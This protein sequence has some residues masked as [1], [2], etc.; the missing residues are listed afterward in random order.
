MSELPLVEGWTGPIEQTLESNGTPVNLTGLTVTLILQK[1]DGSLIDTTGDV[2]VPDPV[3]GLAR[4]T[5]DSTD[6]LAA[7]TPHVARWKVVD[8]G[9]AVIFFPNEQGEVWTVLPVAAVTL[10]DNALLTVAELKAALGI[11]STDQDVALVAFIGA[12][13]DCLE[14][15]TGRRLKS[16]TYT[17]EYRYVEADQVLGAT[18]LDVEWPITA[19]AA[20]EVNGVAQTV[21]LPGDAGSPED[22]DVY[23]LEA[24]DPKHGRDRLYRRSGWTPGSLVKRTYTAGYG[25]AGPPA[26]PIPGDLKEAMRTLAVDWYYHRTRQSEPVVS[27]ATSGETVTYVNEAFPRR[28]R[29]LM[30]AYKRWRA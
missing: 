2:T 22:K 4:Y 10:Q 7:D 16:R 20:L 18:W 24:R 21:W 6:L 13:S 27:R 15:H 25:V 28:F 3:N 26:F 9:G 1:A 12:C 14:T 23:V 8:G 19:I 17:D 30:T 11:K 29:P 5:P